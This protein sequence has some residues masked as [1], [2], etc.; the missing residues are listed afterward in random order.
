M[1]SSTIVL[2]LMQ[3]SVLSSYLLHSENY[4]QNHVL[5]LSLV[6]G[7]YAVMMLLS[8]HCKHFQTQLQALFHL[9]ENIQN[10]AA[11]TT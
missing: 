8:A 11:L 5:N 3:R 7:L 4:S 10:N 1:T 9:K 2:L 6:Q